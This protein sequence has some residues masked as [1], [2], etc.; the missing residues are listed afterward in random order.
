MRICMCCRREERGEGREGR[1][2][3]VSKGKLTVGLQKEA[4]AGKRGW[5]NAD[6]KQNQYP[7]A[8]GC[9]T[10][11]L[12]SFAWLLLNSIRA[13]PAYFLEALSCSGRP[14]KGMA[15]EGGVMVTEIVTR[16]GGSVT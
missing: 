8:C 12:S 15:R 6:T 11:R 9:A 1:G 3:G 10:N 4:K 14:G 5:T 2:S 13:I 16:G 7:M